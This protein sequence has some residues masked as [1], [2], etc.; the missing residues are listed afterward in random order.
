MATRL[1]PPIW[2]R[3]GVRAGELRH[4]AVFLRIPRQQPGVQEHL[5]GCD[6]RAAAGRQFLR[7]PRLRDERVGTCKH[8]EFTLAKL[9]GKRGAKAAFAGGCQLECSELYLRNG[10]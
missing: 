7:R 6:T 5:P 4:R 9:A 3:A 10:A 1:A 8:I 2:P